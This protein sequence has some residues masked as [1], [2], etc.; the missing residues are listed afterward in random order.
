MKQTS[1]PS[2]LLLFMLLIMTARA[3]LPLEPDFAYPR[4]VLKN[5]DAALATSSGLTRMQA[6]MQVV[7]ARTA[8]DPDSLYAMPAFI[9][10]V[11]EKEPDPTVGGLLTLYR[12]RLL[13]DIYGADKYRY[14]NVDA[15]ATPLP[16]D[17]AKWSGEQFRSR[18]AQLTDSAMALIGPAGATA[19]GNYEKVV[20]I[21]AGSPR[22]YPTLLDFASLAAIRNYDSAGDEEASARA[23][24]RALEATPE[25]S[26][27]RAAWIVQTTGQEERWKAYLADPDGEPAGYVL[28]FLNDVPGHDVVKELRR[29]L[30]DNPENA[31][32]AALKDKLMRLTQPTASFNTESVTAPGKEFG[33][34]IS[35]NYTRSAG[36]TLYRITNP[37]TDRR[38]QSLTRIKTYTVDTDPMVKGKSTLRLSIADAGWYVLRPTVNGKTADNLWRDMT[39]QVTPFVPFTLSLGGNNAVILAGYADGAPVPGADIVL[40]NGR[41]TTSHTV[42]RTDA[43]GTVTFPDSR[44]G[45]PRGEHPM[46]AKVNGK[47]YFFGDNVGVSN[48]AE[49]ARKAYIDVAFFLS[50]PIYRPGETVD[51]NVALVNIDPANKT[52]ELAAGRKARVVLFDANYQRVDTADVTTDAY[53]RA[54]GAFKLPADRL[55]G[56]YH[57]GAYVDDKGL[58]SCY[59][60]VSDFKAPVFEVTELKAVRGEAA[61]SAV[62]VTGVARTYAGMAVGGAQVDV[63]VREMPRWRWWFFDPADEDGLFTVTGTTD[64]DGRFSIVI[65]AG[66]IEDDEDYQAAVTVTTRAAETASASVPF[67]TGKPYMLEWGGSERSYNSD[68]P[69]ALPIRAYG[70]DGEKATL[71]VKWRLSSG[72]TVL[73]GSGEVTGKEL[74]IDVKDAPAKEYDLTVE[75]A[76]TA[77]CDILKVERAF[78]LYSRARNLVAPT[79]KLLVLDF[80][81]EVNANGTATVTVGVPVDTYIY[82]A[83]Q[84]DGRLGNISARR[85][86]PGFTELTLHASP[87]LTSTNVVLLGVRDGKTFDKDV[88]LTRPDTEAL[89]LTA[90]SWRDRLVP[91]AAETWRFRLSK[92]DGSPVSG[93]MVATMYNHSLDA[94]GEHL[95]W[96]NIP[97]FISYLRLRANTLNS[98]G[99]YSNFSIDLPPMKA[100]SL[101]FAEPYFRYMDFPGSAL[102]GMTNGIQGRVYAM[103]KAMAPMAKAEEVEDLAAVTEMDESANMMDSGMVLEEKIASSATGEN[104]KEEQGNF[105]FRPGEVLQAFWLP[106]IKVDTD[107]SAVITFTTPDAI[108]TW[109]FHATAWNK[110]L[111]SAGL[112]RDFIADKPLMVQPN[113]PRFLRTG[114]RAR[115]VATVYN[116]TDSEST[117]STRM[118]FFDIVSGRVLGADSVTCAIAAGQS[119]EAGAWIDVPADASMVGCRVKSSNGTYTDGEQIAIPVLESGATVID[120]RNFVL[121]PSR[122]DFTAKLPT[123]ASVIAFQYCQNPVW[124]AVRALPD[125]L[126]DVKPVSSPD[127]AQL[128]YGALTARGLLDG[129]PELK[130]VLEVWKANPAD[131]ALVSDLMKNEDI[132]VAL[133]A[134]TPW[135]NAA[136][137]QTERMARLLAVFDKGRIKAS[138]SRATSAL[139]KLSR[140]DGGFAWGGWSD[141]S[142]L[143]ATTEVAW[144]IGHANALGFVPAGSEA[145]KLARRAL[146]YC[147]RHIGDLDATA[148]AVL[149]SYYPG[150]KPSTLKA[151]QQLAKALQLMLKNWK[152]ADT[153]LKARY[154]LALDANGYKAVAREI[155]QS[156]RQF[157]VTDATGAISFPSVNSVYDYSFIIRAFARISPDKAEL[158]AMRQWVIMRSRV[159]DDLGT[160]FPAPLITS[161]LTSGSR[162]ISAHS[163]ATASV[164]I[165]G[166]PLALDETQYATGAISCRLPLSD[167][168]RTIWVTRAPEG[169]VSYGSVT[170][171][172]A[173]QASE[174]APARCA[175]LAIEKR[176]LVERDG[177]WVA[178]DELRLGE[179]ARVQLLITASTDLDYVTVNDERAAALEPVD[180][181]PG[182]VYASGLAFYREN[183]DS[184]TRLFV[185][186]LPKGTYYLTY[187]MTAACA[188][189]FSSG[190]ATAQSQYAPEVVA[191]SG[192]SRLSVDTRH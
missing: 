146:K 9:G 119:A 90:E 63:R 25:G 15:P 171:V 118:E 164:T 168:G 160:C 57:I 178:V 183:S 105:K 128:A 93:A 126:A 170:S 82:I 120:T 3:Q 12:A 4:D 115:V 108:G 27:R 140:P 100:K 147:D 182:Y 85:L 20:N 77:K 157:E 78:T 117:V 123:D 167:A 185:S 23:G 122:P 192:G 130:D 155:L 33:V 169:P 71:P 28:Y 92:A 14:D 21:P 125:L 116:N 88:E 43:S 127:A 107:G 138:L 186:R 53:G 173:R 159:S 188:G 56:R 106:D 129:F 65:P 99:V 104:G 152:K 37:M 191:R 89:K 175:D 46:V 102:A 31:A 61:D 172:S 1:R 84:K 18:I 136:S 11:A 50:R 54:S 103:R 22:Y 80:R 112:A 124:D 68:G 17:P 153:S 134:Q 151:E 59:F 40:Y 121:T 69:L 132:K 143:W 137:S 133:L 10:S 111:R 161:V 95:E 165:D 148:Y 26:L 145:D 179:R 47:S 98:W 154:A 166:A 97:R 181:L 51:W 30:A 8:I 49:S 62:T 44:I 135:L 5:A 187:D 139:D 76:D 41:K 144:A 158:D 67:T 70:P 163:S 2:V 74:V 91:G 162:W 72:E 42:G 110:E 96:P 13:A 7:T 39:V 141:E 131:S 64:A 113:A 142:S 66:Q 180:Q 38:K 189:E 176:L 83:E 94:L 184:R 35:H 19:I 48:Y 156:V 114:D 24:H 79:E 101:A 87:G 149:L 36:V 174:V 55:T 6:A 150:Y 29:Y 16:A 45:T 75:P 60:M 32:T 190:I 34:T 177:A 86:T 52:S 109:A 58:G 73:E 81:P